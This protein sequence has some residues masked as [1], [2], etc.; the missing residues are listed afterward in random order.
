MPYTLDRRT[1]L[2][3][4]GA[5]ALAGGGASHALGS[6]TA[7]TW[8]PD[9]DTQ[10]Q[11][12]E[13]MGRH[14]VPGVAIAILEDGEL[15]WEGGFGTRNIETGAPVRTTTLFQAAS[16]TK[17]VFAYVV[18]RL[19]DAGRIDLDDRLVDYY[20]PEDLVMSDQ[21]AAVTVRHVLTHQTGLPNWRPADDQAAML[22]PAF[23]PGSGYSYSGEAFHWLQQVCEAITGLGVHDLTDQQLFTPA[24]L[25]DMAM[26]WRADRDDR[27]VYGHIVG[28]DGEA[29]LS[30]LQFAREQGWRLQEVAERWGRP[31]TRWRSLDLQAA[32]AVM[33]P[34]DHPRL[35]DRPLWRVNRPGSAVIST[36]SSLRTTPGDYA[37]FLALVMSPTEPS[38]GGI[39]EPLREMMLT[40]QTPV[41]PN[42]PNR[43]IG[44]SWSLEAVEGGVAYDHWGFNARQHISM[45]LGDTSNRRGIVIMTNGSQ[46]NTFMDEIGP[47]IT[48]TDYRSFF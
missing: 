24:G 39:S 22:Q 15:V 38:A 5:S 9:Q 16:L 12:R 25:N 7:E 14:R 20:R 26:L 18:L 1:A 29:E 36:A 47:I 30:A 33:Q 28:D 13:A 27:E 19:V 21:S 34:H 2:K 46:G 4:F 42:G 6:T 10:D 17:P 40:P 44:L 43:P 37:R 41:S 23:E 11:V 32:H 48:G 35:A 8:I 45:A 3:L 31:M